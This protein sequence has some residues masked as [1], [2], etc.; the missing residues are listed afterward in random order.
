[1]ILYNILEWLNNTDVKKYITILLLTRNI[2]F[3][4]KL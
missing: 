2:T 4:D 3:V 1:M